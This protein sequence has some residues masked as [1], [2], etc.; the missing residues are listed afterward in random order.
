MESSAVPPGKL[1]DEGETQFYLKKN[2]IAGHYLVLCNSVQK[3]KSF[4][5]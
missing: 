3:C 2:V 1:N 5:P 4:F